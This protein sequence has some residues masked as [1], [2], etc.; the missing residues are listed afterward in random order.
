MSELP[1]GEP[2]ADSVVLVLDTSVVIKWYRQ[3]EILAD[4]ALALRDAY[5]D[6]QIALAVPSLLAYELAN[7]LR[8]KQDMTL[9]DVQAAVESLYGIGLEWLMPSNTM[10]RR[11]VEIART[12]E[13]TVYDATF[14]ALAEGL[15]GTFVTAD[16]RL[17]R[18]LPTSAPV[19]FLGDVQDS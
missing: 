18:A 13:T 1:V 3:G 4:Q 5:L 6:G 2:L 11:A 15:N 16:Q 14:V 7:V 19:R 17:V 12:Y 10:I 9:E 8:F